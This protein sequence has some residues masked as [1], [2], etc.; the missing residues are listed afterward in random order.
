VEIKLRRK[1]SLGRESDRKKISM[2]E[3]PLTEEDITNQKTL[4]NNG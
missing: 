2:V 4:G 3:I 1:Y